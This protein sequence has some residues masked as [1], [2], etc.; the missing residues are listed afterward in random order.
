MDTPQERDRSIASPTRPRVSVIIPCFN[1]SAPLRE[2]VESV[3]AQTYR[4][5][6][7]LIIDDGSTDDTRATVENRFG[8]NPR[9][10]YFHKNH[11]GPGPARNLGLRH[12]AGEYIAFLDSDDL[13]L[14]DKLEHQVRQL[15]ED[16]GAA[17]SFTDA[18]MRDASPGR[19]TRFQSHGFKGETTVKAIVESTFPLCTPAVVIRRRVFDEIGNFDESLACAQ[20]WDLWIRVLAVHRAAYLERPGLVIRTG[21]DSISR[22]RALEKWRCWLRVWEK[23][24]ELLLSSGCTPR[25]V[26]GRLAHAHKKIA[27]ACLSSG[28]Y[29]EAKSH[30]RD[31]WRCQP[32][33]IRGVLWWAALSILRL[34][35][36]SE[37]RQ[38]AA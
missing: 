21:D 33:Q 14:P 16:S 36:E 2:A 31:W 9:I 18:F 29:A 27:Q 35:R 8:G 38:G 1:R 23:H 4:D 28:R 22:T 13:W 7:I 17:L 26:R 15:E 25:S 20:D 10:K 6:E 19:K 30:Y 24:R 34:G 3:L 5:F 11:G 12:A 32:W 37:G